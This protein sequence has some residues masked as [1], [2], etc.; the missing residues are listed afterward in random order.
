VIGW[1]AGDNYR[2]PLIEQTTEM[3][4]RNCPLA[5]NSIFHSDRGSNYTPQQFA[6]MLKKYN[7]W[8]S[9]GHTGIYDSAMAESFFAALNER[10]TGP[11]IP[12]VSTRTVT[13]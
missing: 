8:Q 9:V 1:A 5:A 10:V 4:A 2:T 11:S 13:L 12:L 7:P 3:A 6:R